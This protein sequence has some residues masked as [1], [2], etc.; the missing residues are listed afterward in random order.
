MLSHVSSPSPQSRSGPVL[1]PQGPLELHLPPVLHAAPKPLATTNLSSGHLKNV[2]QME[3]Y[4]M[5]CVRTILSIMAWDPA[6]VPCVSIVCSFLL[7]SNIHG[8]GAAACLTI[9][10]SKHI[11]VV[12]SV[13]LWWRKLRW[14][15]MCRLLC[16]RQFS[17]LWDES[18]RG[19]VLGFVVI[20]CLVLF[21]KNLLNFSR[22]PG[23][24]CSI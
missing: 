17:F 14:T 16:E 21:L 24:F 1:S 5:Q 23:T 2:I 13:W 9:Y 20:G 8:T 18:L 11:W 22:A 12:A 19:R 4:K 3:S 15:F 7:L 10:Q 6:E